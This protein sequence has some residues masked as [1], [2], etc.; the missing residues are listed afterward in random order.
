MTRQSQLVTIIN[1]IDM[2]GDTIITSGNDSYVRVFDLEGFQQ[3]AS[4]EFPKPVNRASRQPV[5]KTVAVA[6][7]DKAARLIDGDS[8]IEISQLNGHEDYLFA[9]G[10]H[11]DGQMFATGAQDSAAFGI[12]D[13]YRNL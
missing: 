12:C 11:P 1:T 7:D 9:T 6:L 10:W 5:G 2:L 4:F 8:G 3:K 13:I